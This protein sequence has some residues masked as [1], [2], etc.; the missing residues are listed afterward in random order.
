MLLY[1]KF[2]FS[3]SFLTYLILASILIITTAIDIEH[4][5]IP[6]ELVFIGIIAGV[7]LVLTGLSVHWKDALIGLLVGGGTFLAVALLSEWILKKEGS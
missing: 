6:D 1:L 5:I 7:V 2:G 3:G 4:Q